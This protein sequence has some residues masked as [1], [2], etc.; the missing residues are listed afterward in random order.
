M[1]ILFAAGGGVLGAVYLGVTLSGIVG[2][3]LIQLDVIPVTGLLSVMSL[4]ALPVGFLTAR[5]AWQRYPNLCAADTPGMTALIGAI[6][7]GGIGLAL[8]ILGPPLLHFGGPRGA[9]LGYFLTGPLGALLGSLGGQLY[10]RL[11]RRARS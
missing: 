6:I 4:I 8:G 1:R 7:M 9:L 10:W 5:S 11:G 3:F 2:T